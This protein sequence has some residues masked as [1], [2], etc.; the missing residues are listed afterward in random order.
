MKILENFSENFPQ[1]LKIVN[2]RNL[3]ETGKCFGKFNKTERGGKFRRILKK[4]FKQYLKHFNRN[5]V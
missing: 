2:I 5:F 3:A 4:L 1:N